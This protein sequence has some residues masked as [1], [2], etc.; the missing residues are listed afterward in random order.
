MPTPADRL[1][2]VKTFEDLVTY[3]QDE[4]DWPLEDYPFDELTFEYTPEELG[5]KADEAAKVRTIH[6][7]RPL[8]DGQPW[9]I[10]F[11]EFERKRLPVV[12][13]RRILSHLVIK[14]RAA[15]Y[16]AHQAAW[17]L[18]D[19]L[20]ISAFGDDGRAGDAH[21]DEREIAFAHFRQAEGDLPTLRVLG[22]DGADTGLKLDHVAHVLG[23][24]LCWPDDPTDADAWREQ[25]AAAFRHR[26]GHIIRTSDALAERLAALARGIRYAAL[27]LMAHE[28]E[29]GSLRQLHKAFQTALIH[30]LTTTDF[31]DTYAQT[32]T[33]GLLTAAISSTDMTAGRH[34]TALHAGKLA[35]MVP[36][37][38]PFLKEML[39]TFLQAGG[40]N[41]GI[42]FDELGV[43]E[44]VDLLRGDET[45][46]PAILRDFGNKTHGEDPVI[47]FYEHFLAAYDKKL[48]VQRG[49]FYTPKPVVSYIVRSVHELL[50][51]EFG[52]ADGLAD[53]ATWGEVAARTPGLTIPE[54]TQPDAPFVVI[55]DP[56][57]GT[58]TFL[59][60]VIDV[61]HRTMT[62]DDGE[63]AARGAERG[64]AARD[65]ER[66][67]TPAPAPPPARLRADDGALRHRA[68]ED[69]LEA[70]GDGLPVRRQRGA[71]AR[72]PDQC[73]GAGGRGRG[74]VAVC[75]VGPRPRARGAGGECGQAVAAVYGGGGESAV[76]EFWTVESDALDSWPA[77]RL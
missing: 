3:L 57:T 37:T 43:Q 19:L 7:L 32:V 34:G 66:L 69:R 6:Q 12:V 33:Y 20:F 51:S 41:G 71:R 72:V 25:W 42:N 60:E 24:R 38:N 73:A 17:A 21:A 65:V 62:D 53:T 50:Q 75:R 13:L 70:V 76:C 35:E 28:T 40:Q 61:V 58:G 5:L 30:D 46:L 44:V 36:L 52:L 68:H 47:F 1:R 31:A 45:D 22:W 16:Q 77:G 14:K 4:L 56:A 63:V 23:E 39:G 2:K 18:G 54:G 49:S 10:F 8:Y 9:G 64:A 15:S 55:L 29:R 26:V 27:T 59:V 11:V 48:K 74:A 67:R